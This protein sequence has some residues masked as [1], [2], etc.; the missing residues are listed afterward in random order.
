MPKIKTHGGAAKR[1]TL[2]KTGK[3]KHM[4]QNRRHKL[5]TKTTKRK[6]GLRT[7]AYASPAVAANIKKMIPYA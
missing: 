5:T 4:Q 1:F 7:S 2:T 6:R 3:V